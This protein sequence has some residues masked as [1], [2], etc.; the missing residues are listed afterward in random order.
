MPQPASDGRAFMP[1]LGSDRKWAVVRYGAACSARGRRARHSRSDRCATAGRAGGA[2]RE[3]V[4]ATCRRVAAQRCPNERGG[5]PVAPRRRRLRGSRRSSA[6]SARAARASAPA[7]RYSAALS[8]GECIAPARARTPTPCR[9]SW[10]RQR[11]KD[12]RG[13]RR[14]YRQRTEDAR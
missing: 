4:A 6:H 12:H 14:R 11:L 1:G 2:A 7:P 9:Q 5:S 13:W 10:C 3:A 8:G